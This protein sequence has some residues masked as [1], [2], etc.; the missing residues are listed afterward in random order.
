MRC[1]CCGRCVDASR[2]RLAHHAHVL[3]ALARRVWQSVSLTAVEGS[4]VRMGERRG[5]L[6]E[7]QT[8]GSAAEA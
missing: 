2:G 5:T 4:V 1:G 7:A 8:A 6:L 3:T